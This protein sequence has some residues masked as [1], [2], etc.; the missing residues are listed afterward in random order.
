MYEQEV[1]VD[2]DLLSDYEKLRSEKIKRNEERLKDLGLYNFVKIVKP[3]P[4]QK[5]K[6]K[7]TSHG[8]QRRSLRK[9]KMIVDYSEERFVPAQNDEE[10]DADGVFKIYDIDA[11]DH[12]DD[13][14]LF[15]VEKTER[16]KK[17]MRRTNKL[18]KNKEI[19]TAADTKAANIM[20]EKNL[21]GDDGL[22]LEL[23]KTGRST[24]RKC[25]NK[26]DKGEPRVGMLSWIVGRN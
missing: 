2:V 4:K 14:V 6:K 7:I 16:P 1:R 24:C 3:T 25:L 23:A 9:R 13:D 20:I 8:P 5:A 26:I 12:D 10:D 19:A 11:V 21:A 22:T 17:K 18:Q 15:R